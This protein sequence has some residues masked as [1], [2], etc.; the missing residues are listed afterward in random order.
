MI[1]RHVRLAF[2][3][4]AAA[5][6]E[7]LL[8]MA[9]NASE[10]PTRAD[11]DAF[12]D[13][14][15]EVDPDIR[16]LR[17]T[18]RSDDFLATAGEGIGGKVDVLH[19]A[20][21]DALRALARGVPGKATEAVS[22]GDIGK[23]VDVLRYLLEKKS[24]GED[25]ATMS[26]GLREQMSEIHAL[27][28]AGEEIGR[29][30]N[31]L[32]ESKFAGEIPSFV[33]AYKKSKP[34]GSGKTRWQLL[35]E[36]LGAGAQAA[37]EATVLQMVHKSLRRMIDNEN[38]ADKND[39]MHAFNAVLYPVRMAI[40]SGVTGDEFDPQHEESGTRSARRNWARY[41]GR[42]TGL[43]QFGGKGLDRQAVLEWINENFVKPELAAGTMVTAPRFPGDSEPVTAP[44]LRHKLTKK[45]LDR[46][47]LA[48]TPVRS[49]EERSGDEGVSL[50]EQ[51]ETRDVPLEQREE[52][53]VEYLDKPK[54]RQ[55]IRAKVKQY[56]RRAT[57]ELPATKR[58]K[59]VRT[60]QGLDA[61]SDKSR[62]LYEHVLL[63]KLGFGSDTDRKGFE[64]AWVANE[65]FPHRPFRTETMSEDL[66][67]SLKRP[68]RRGYK[69]DPDQA[70]HKGYIKR[71]TQTVLVNRQTGAEV[72][73]ITDVH[74]EEDWKLVKKVHKVGEQPSRSHFVNWVEYTKEDRR[75]DIRQT[76]NAYDGQA[77]FKRS[78]TEDAQ[79]SL[80]A[81][82]NKGEAI[83]HIDPSRVFKGWSKNVDIP[84]L[85]A[86]G[87]TRQS[88][89]VQYDSLFPLSSSF[90]WDMSIIMSKFATLVDEDVERDVKDAEWVW[91]YLYLKGK[92]RIASAR[93]FRKEAMDRVI[94]SVVAALAPRN[95]A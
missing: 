78:L 25:R 21:E 17:D 58:E 72:K 85:R 29:A 10:N 86:L 35:R 26:V 89:A 37:A 92:G 36:Q 84:M 22:S 32:L 59:A 73:S 79:K 88:V 8:A 69:N 38:Y 48:V 74:T 53:Q 75:E 81:E 34:P 7:A 42:L 82:A 80:E 4:L 13:K 39:D 63:V 93:A 45:T 16:Q 3:R 52:Y 2:E 12:L 90:A 28:V 76:L 65:K 24:R 41:V 56:A 49:L 43:P 27:S 31:D 60:V 54:N 87:Q 83:G 68:L 11:T 30:V 9:E 70:P 18:A 46:W 57:R 64:E 95:A 50:G 61:A 33:E 20:I 91:V 14:L 23:L 44:P 94:R 55:E 6:A 51:V 15:T 5:G 1:T 71:W 67:K 19:E 62:S 66:W 40:Q 47:F 77:W